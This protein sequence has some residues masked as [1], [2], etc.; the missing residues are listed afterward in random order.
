MEPPGFGSDVPH[1]STAFASSKVPTAFFPKSFSPAMLPG[2]ATY[3]AEPP[4]KTSVDRLLP[5]FRSATAR[6]ADGDD[7]TSPGPGHYPSPS[8]FP[9]DKIRRA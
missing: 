9:E 8:N 7:V 5:A 3:F 2:P 4:V 6:F 1:C